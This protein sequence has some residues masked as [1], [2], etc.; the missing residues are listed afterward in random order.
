[1]AKKVTINLLLSSEK[2]DRFTLQTWLF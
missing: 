2:E 1:M